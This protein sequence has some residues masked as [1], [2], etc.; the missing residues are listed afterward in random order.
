[1]VS[2][3]GWGAG[4]SDLLN[5]YGSLVGSELGC[6]SVV[7]GSTRGSYLE[8][9]DAVRRRGLR[10]CL[11]AFGASPV[12]GL[13]AEAGGPSLG[14]RRLELS[15]R[16]VGR[17]VA[18]PDDPACDCVIDPIC[19]DVCRRHGGGAPPFGVQMEP[20]LEAIHL[21]TGAV[22]PVVASGCPP[23]GL[24][25]PSFIFYRRGCRGSDTSPL[26]L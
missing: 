14:D 4:A 8:V 25:R 26:F 21:E 11:G 15:L 5:L 19:V 1:M 22:T 6:G 13:C 17:L 2:S 16:C 23:W 9:L 18:Y 7:C 3:A 24:P 20:H 10:L 12:E